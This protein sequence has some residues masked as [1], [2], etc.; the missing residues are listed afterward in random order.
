LQTEAQTPLHFA[1]AGLH[2]DAVRTLLANAAIDVNKRDGFGRTFLHVVF[3]NLNASPATRRADIIALLQSLSQ[4]NQQA[5]TDLL[6]SRES[7]S[8]DTVLVCR[9]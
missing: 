5:F 2:S 7:H 1:A 8:L 9:V 4:Q 6:N 3:K